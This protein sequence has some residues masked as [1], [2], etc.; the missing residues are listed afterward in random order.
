MKNSMTT[1]EKIEYL[2]SLSHFTTEDFLMLTDCLRERCPWDR[3]QN[4]KSIRTSMIEEAYEAADAIDRDDMDNLCE[5]LGDVML[6]ITLHSRMASEKDDFDYNDVIDGICHKMIIRHPHVFGDT[7]AKTSEQVLNNWD[8]IKAKTKGQTSKQT[9][10]DIPKSLPSLMRAQKIAKRAAKAGVYELN[11]DYDALS[12]DEAKKQI[13]KKIFELC[14]AAESVGFDIE[15]A[16]YSE[17]D[18]F[19]SKIIKN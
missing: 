6:Q 13:S 3:E 12:A 9:I 10:K 16:L 11:H 17:N 7:D 15:E 2:N 5:E 8:K 18:D 4:H 14:S 19:L 1:D